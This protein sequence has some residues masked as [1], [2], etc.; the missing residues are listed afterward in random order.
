VAGNGLRCVI[1]F[2]SSQVKRRRRENG[3]NR[4]VR[5][6][7]TRSINE[8]GRPDG[9]PQLEGSGDPT[10]QSDVDGRS[11]SRGI[12]GKRKGGG[13]PDKERGAA[14]LN[15]LLTIPGRL[16]Y[17]ETWKLDTSITGV[18]TRRKRIRHKEHGNRRR[19]KRA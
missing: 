14:C 7:F 4:Q 9:S 3:L 17:R 6:N 18:K 16:E 5:R 2:R 15:E 19:I 12:P 13:R 11:K 1:I 10:P 8:G